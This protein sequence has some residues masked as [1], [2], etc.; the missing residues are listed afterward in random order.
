MSL[1]S[2]G[3]LIFILVYSTLGALP[4]S[5]SSGLK[6]SIIGIIYAAGRAIL[7]FGSQVIIFSRAISPTQVLKAFLSFVY[8]IISIYLLIQLSLFFA[9]SIPFIDIIINVLG[10]YTNSGLMIDGALV[11]D[12]I[13]LKL[14]L[15]IS[16]IIGRLGLLLIFAW[17]K[18]PRYVAQYPDETIVLI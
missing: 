10:S 4:L 14:L 7:Y 13:F 6:T 17:Y 1:L 3:L 8:M 18:V 5:T 12:S 9:S 2:P 11:Q 15:I 16:M